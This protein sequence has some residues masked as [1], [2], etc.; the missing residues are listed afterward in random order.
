MIREA[1]QKEATQQIIYNNFKGIVYISPRVGKTK[2]TLDALEAFNNNIYVIYPNNDIKSSWYHEMEKWDLFYNIT[3]CNQRS[4]HKIDD[5]NALIICD[6]GHTLSEHQLNLLKKLQARGCKILV[7]TGTLAD[8]TKRN[9]FYSLGLEI[10]YE[11]QID[12]AIDDDIIANYEIN[13][14]LIDLDDTDKYVTAKKNKNSSFKTTEVRAYQFY[15]DLF[16]NYKHKQRY[17]SK[18]K[19]I[20][21]MYAKY[22]KDMIYTSKTKIQKAKELFDNIDEKCIIYTMFTN[23]ADTLCE[24]SYHSK[25]DENNLNKFI[26]NEINKLSACNMVS[27]GK[28]YAPVCGNTY[29]KF[30]N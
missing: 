6:E 10:I 28:R 3:F 19:F 18:A 20:K 30:K 27:M 29:G 15:T 25:S 26:N 17:S 11:Y 21:M 16:Y 4:L 12:S 8:D 1:I 2:L 24:N 9:L 22:R 7:T 23:V 5:D 13:V 14:M